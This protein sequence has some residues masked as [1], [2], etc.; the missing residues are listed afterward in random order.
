MDI[1][2]HWPGRRGGRATV[3]ARAVP[4]GSREPGPRKDRLGPADG[5]QKLIVSGEAG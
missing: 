5:R 4:G 1:E 2:W 3:R